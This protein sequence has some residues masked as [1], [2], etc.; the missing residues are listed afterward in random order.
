MLAEV[1]RRVVEAC[2][3]ESIV[4]FGSAARGEMT[5]HS[6]L[7]LLVIKGGKYSHDRV[8][9][10]IYKSLSGIDH[11]VDVVLATPEDIE[12]YRDSWC[13]VY[14]P[15]LREGRNIYG[16]RA[17]IRRRSQEW[18]NRAKSNFIRAGQA[19]EGVYLEDLCFDAQ[20]A[21]EKPIKAVFIKNGID[22]PYTHNI[23]KLLDLLVEAKIVVPKYLRAAETLTQYAA[24][25]RYP[26]TMKPATA[27]VHRQAVR[28]AEKV[29]RW[30]ERKVGAE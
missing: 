22:F 8:A 24:L 16:K 5:E 12:R 19:L 15:A 9:T 20:Q 27:R 2:E 13:L 28:I 18:L 11:S 7:D 25:G 30:A 14:Y 17:T 1:V 10:A 6:D 23:A 4:L 21:V 3:P 26:G 29:L